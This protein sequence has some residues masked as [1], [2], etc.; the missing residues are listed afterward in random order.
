MGSLRVTNI[1]LSILVVLFAL[2]EALAWVRPVGRYTYRYDTGGSF[3]AFDTATGTMY[4]AAQENKEGILDIVR[5][6]K[7]Q[8][9]V[10]AK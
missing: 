1:L 10:K 6:A 7:A 4:M 8:Q 2:H 3:S 9:K 5:T